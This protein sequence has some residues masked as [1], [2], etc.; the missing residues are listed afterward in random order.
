MNKHFD[1]WLIWECITTPIQLKRYLRAVDTTEEIV[2]LH[3]S[4]LKRDYPR[5]RFET[6]ERIANHLMG[7][8][9]DLALREG[10][11]SRFKDGD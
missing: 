11:V 7:H 1:I 2:N 3:L 10:Q 9:M 4:S 6:E 8:N 5:S